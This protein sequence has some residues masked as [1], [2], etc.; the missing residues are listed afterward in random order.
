[1]YE[2]IYVS[3]VSKSVSM[4]VRMYVCIEQSKLV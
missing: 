4:Y 1:M 2:C 3:M